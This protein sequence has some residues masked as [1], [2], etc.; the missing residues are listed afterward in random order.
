MYANKW[1]NYEFPLQC[2]LA[3]DFNLF[4]LVSLSLGSSDLDH[5]LANA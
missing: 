4:F 3:F 5:S 1:R 2:K